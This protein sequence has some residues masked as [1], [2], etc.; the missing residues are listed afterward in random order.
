MQEMSQNFL[1]FLYIAL[2]ASQEAAVVIEHYRAFP[3]DLAIKT[4]P[5]HSRVTSADY[6]ANALLEY[7][8]GAT[9][10][11][12]VSEENDVSAQKGERHWL[13]DPLDGTHI[14]IDSIQ[15]KS[16]LDYYINVAMI[17]EAGEP[18]L[19]V[20]YE[21]RKQEALFTASGMKS[22]YCKDIDR[23]LAGD[24]L[25]LDAAEILQV[26]TPTPQYLTATFN[27]RGKKQD[28]FYDM[29]R[30]K[31]EPH[32]SLPKHPQDKS[33]M[34]GMIDVLGGRADMAVRS[35][36]SFQSGYPHDNA[37]WWLL[38]KNAGGEMFFIDEAPE[39]SREIMFGVQPDFNVKRRMP[40]FVARKLG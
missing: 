3:G 6:A 9:A 4:K 18:V 19:G 39:P 5:D 13:I 7:R 20:I 2:K 31:L 29:M 30:E 17:G 36:E 24:R 34:G 10:I 12:V 15:G 28:R 38:L 27:L 32:L 11:K 25:N 40:A 33:P 23:L 22:Y 37:P 16:K 1:Q 14:F 8:L 35:N 21:P 26:R